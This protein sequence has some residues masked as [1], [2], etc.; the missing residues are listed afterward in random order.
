MLLDRSGL[1]E[2]NMPVDLQADIS[3]T[4]LSGLL[5]GKSC[6]Y[7]WGKQGEEL[8]YIRIGEENTFG[9]ETE[10]EWMTLDLKSIAEESYP[11]PAAD[12]IRWLSPDP[13]GGE[14]QD[15]RDYVKQLIYEMVSRDNSVSVPE[16]LNRINGLLGDSAFRLV[17]G[18]YVN[19]LVQEHTQVR[20]QFQTRREKITGYELSVLQQADQSQ[21]GVELDISLSGKEWKI[22]LTLAENVNEY[23]YISMD[24]TMEE[25]SQRPEGYLP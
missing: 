24:G 23:M 4:V 13:Y 11:V 1:F 12:Y 20:V 25:T 19:E 10:Q 17:K 21:P 3:G 14:Q 15:A 6:L 2:L 18:S 5:S 8:H 7:A 9:A 16:L 22:N